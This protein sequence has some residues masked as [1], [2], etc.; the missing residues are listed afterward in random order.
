MTADQRIKHSS[1]RSV[2]IHPNDM[3]EPLDINTLS[4]VHVI[5]ELMQ[6]PV[7]SYILCSTF[8]SNTPKAAASVLDSV[9]VS[10][11]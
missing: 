7:G 9:H 3:A 6:R 8:L 10:A 11:P 1:W 2:F 5:A 4:K